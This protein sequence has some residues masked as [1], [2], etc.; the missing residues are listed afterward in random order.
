MLEDI[1]V[2]LEKEIEKLKREMTK[3]L[4][5][6]KAVH[7][8]RETALN[9]AN[10]IKSKMERFQTKCEMEWASLNDIIQEN[11]RAQVER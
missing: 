3:I 2:G 4:K 10:D 5:N 8:T 6:T 7:V 9:E 11:R 1:N